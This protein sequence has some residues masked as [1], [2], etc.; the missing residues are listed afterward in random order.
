MAKPD[1]P[2]KELLEKMG[3]IAYRKAKLKYRLDLKSAKDSSIGWFG[4]AVHPLQ[5]LETAYQGLAGEA[6][7]SV[8]VANN[9]NAMDERK[10]KCEEVLKKYFVSPSVTPAPIRENGSNDTI[11]ERLKSTKS[12]VSSLSNKLY[13]KDEATIGNNDDLLKLAKEAFE[14]FS[15]EVDAVLKAF[16]DL[17]TK[18]RPQPNPNAP[19][20]YPSPI[21]LDA[22]DKLQTFNTDRGTIDTQT[23]PDDKGKLVKKLC[24]TN[25]SELNKVVGMAADGL[26]QVQM[27]YFIDA[28]YLFRL[29]VPYSVIADGEV[30]GGTKGDASSALTEMLNNN[31]DGSDKMK[32][33]NDWLIAKMVSFADELAKIPDADNRVFFHLKGGRALQYLLG[34]PEMGE[35]DWD[36]AI[37][38]N[39]NLP[40]NEW[41]ETFNQVHDVVLKELW[42]AKNEFFV[43]IHENHG[44]TDDRFDQVSNA[45]PQAALS[46]PLGYVSEVGNGCK[47]ELID[48]GIPRRDT[49]EAA[50]QWHLMGPKEDGDKSRVIRVNSAKWTDNVPIPPHSYF[51]DEYILMAREALANVSPKP[52]K[53]CKRIRRL[54]DI[55]NL[56]SGDSANM[57]TKAIDEHYKEVPD[58]LRKSLDGKISGLATDEQRFAKVLYRQFVKSYDLEGD[59]GLGEAFGK[60]FVAEVDNRGNLKPNSEVKAGIDEDENKHKWKDVE[61]GKILQWALLADK[62]SG[63]RTKKCTMFEKHFM[64]RQKFFGFERSV[65]LPDWG[66]TVSAQIPKDPKDRRKKL[67]SF[68]KS[69]YNNMLFDDGGASEWEVRLAVT[70]SLAVF[71]HADEARLEKNLMDK[72][73][74][75]RTIDLKIFTYQPS[76][77]KDKVVSMFLKP[78]LDRYYSGQGVKFTHQ[79]G[80]DD[81]L[82]LF[83]PEKVKIGEDLDPYSPVIFKLSFE[84]P[85][86]WPVLSNVTGFPVVSLRYLARE[87]REKAAHAEEFGRKNVLKETMSM[88][89]LMMTRFDQETMGEDFEPVPAAPPMED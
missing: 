89:E 45:S 78:A 65:D 48:V 74:P 29:L 26:A 34:T 55:M 43:K 3:E 24:N 12:L 85:G 83:W 41:Y 27:L 4:S 37:V 87:Y 82:L 39:P 63:W 17:E 11:V 42:K 81:S 47:A 68:I 8:P 1:N 20:P 6:M 58:N 15:A 32:W 9:P 86:R 10:Q 62:L 72:L 40:P 33:I 16:K 30:D 5:P 35:N 73:D 60:V 22:E 28:F 44:D 76:T 66:P 50:E 64:D 88:I 49:A 53:M 51:I 7:R 52:R 57:L 67:T 31:L 38:I 80:S 70:G 79:N 13:A 25:A 2:G 21:I 54:S 75:I 77:K 71:L 23:T 84:K 18:N 69:L 19:S 46:A 36:T 14:K 56:T 59:P 61:H